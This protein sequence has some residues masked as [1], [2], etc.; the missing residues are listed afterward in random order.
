[1]QTLFLSV[2]YSV[3]IGCMAYAYICNLL[4]TFWVKA[5]KSAGLYSL[6]NALLEAEGVFI[7]RAGLFWF[8]SMIFLFKSIIK[9]K[10][11]PG[12]RSPDFLEISFSL[13]PLV[14][15]GL[16]IAIVSIPGFLLAAITNHF[17]DKEQVSVSIGAALMLSLI[18]WGY[19]AGKKLHT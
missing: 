3:A 9:N 11:F 18:L 1:M 19:L 10:G 2:F 4:H 14:V 6:H 5:S 13:I 15:F 7:S 8:F 12:S 16:V 17:F